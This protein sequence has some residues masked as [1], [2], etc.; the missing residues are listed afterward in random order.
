MLPFHHRDL[1]ESWSCSLTLTWWNIRS[2][3]ATLTVCSCGN[4]K[5]TPTRLLVQLGPCK[6]LLLRE[7]SN[8]IR[9]VSGLLGLR[10]GY[11]ASTMFSDRWL[12]PLW[13]ELTCILLYNGFFLGHEG[14][15]VSD[16]KAFSLPRICYLV[17]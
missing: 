14:I 9:T 11:V 8:T 16:W 7:A 3:S 12:R 17:T 5:R 4:L 1:K 6:R 13:C 15:F 2:I 10:P